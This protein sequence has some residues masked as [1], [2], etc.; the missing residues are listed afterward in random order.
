M[1]LFPRVTFFA[2]KFNSDSMSRFVATSLRSS[3]F[4]AIFCMI[5]G[6]NISL[7][8]CFIDKSLSNTKE[9]N[10]FLYILAIW[11]AV[12]LLTPPAV[13]ASTIVFSI[14]TTAF[15]LSLSFLS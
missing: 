3:M 8:V 6:V 11:R 1:S 2:T 12:L 14:W 4:C 13:I 9:I 10:P 15:W 7:A 5:N